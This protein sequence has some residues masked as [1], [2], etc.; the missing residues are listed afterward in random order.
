[1]IQNKKIIGVCVAN[2]QDTIHTDYIMRLKHQAEKQGCKL[3]IFNNYVESGDLKYE[4]EKTIYNIINYDIIDILIVFYDDFY[5]K[6][7]AD[8]IIFDAKKHEIPVYIY[9]KADEPE[10]FLNSEGAGSAVLEKNS[11][12]SADYINQ[13]LENNE[14][15]IFAWIN[16]VLEIKD[17]NSFYTL[18][19]KRI[20][21]NSYICLK[22]TFI[23]SMTKN[24]DGRDVASEDYVILASKPSCDESESSGE[25]SKMK[26]DNMVADMESWV[27]DNTMYVINAICV[28]HEICGYY[29]VRTNNIAN[30]NQKIDCVLKSINVSCKVAINYFRQNNSN[31]SI[32]KLT[33]TN[34]VTGLPNLKG[35]VKWFDEFSAIPENKEK[36]LTISIYALPKY[37]YIYEN[38]GIE[39]LEEAIQVVAE[40]LK[41][42]NNTKCF[43][44]HIT[45]D[46]FVIVNYYDDPNEISDTINN[47]TSTFFGMMESYNRSSDKEYYVEVNCGCTTVKP[48]WH[49]SLE[50][51]IKRANSEMYM[52]RIKMEKGSATKEFSAPKEHY[53]AFELLIER[54][55]FHYYFQP[56]VSAKTGEIY[57]YEALMRTD[58]GIGMNPLEVLEVARIYKR[59]YEIEKATM[60]NVMERFA[61]DYESFGNSK[62]FINTIPGYF[63]KDE[64][65][66]ILSE[67][68]GEYMDRFVYELTEQ[69]TVSDNELD[70]IKKLCG[71]RTKSQIAIDDYGTGH[72]NIVNL[73]RY[74]PQVIKIDRMLITD[75]HKNQNKQMFVRSTIE[76]A[77]MNNIMVLAEGVETLNELRMV[78][79]LGVDL[80]QGYYTG[81]PAPE[82][83][84]AI[85]EDIRKE[86]EEANSLFCQN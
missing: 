58:A 23:S 10:I 11:E 52:N 70:S 15:F 38:Y 4:E 19:E 16:R 48:K 18:F 46:A 61:T 71:K 64:D 67:K 42:T 53:K 14:D 85:S 8:N 41:V 40:T 44:G 37:T 86:I 51:Y 39:N 72:S 47:A 56:I 62:V 21:A 20:P 34:L 83:I 78:I 45:E 29:M 35:S 81:R 5:N 59:L 32:E 84:G 60:F 49:H 2:I 7:V 6:N 75:I 3:I 68:Y 80:I 77:R 57:G 73:M 22:D 30:S 55:L 13:E 50:R 43:V 76:F 1:M 28:A 17:L 36:T 82:P 25:K 65:I 9:N 69:N 26:L 24:I 33:L 27:E 63:L 12:T 54:N 31:V 74:A 66:N 79:N